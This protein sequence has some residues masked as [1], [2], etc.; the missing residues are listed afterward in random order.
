MGGS[1]KGRHSHRTREGHGPPGRRQLNTQDRPI[2]AP[3]GASVSWFWAR[4]KA[5]R[6]CNGTGLEGGALAYQA[7]SRNA[8][9]VDAS[10]LSAPGKLT[11]QS[12]WRDANLGCDL[13]PL[14]L[15]R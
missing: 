11:I 3:R 13:T 7:F 6:A 4:I 8:V 2:V 9:I 14:S 5:L 10:R 12:F 15:G 1:L